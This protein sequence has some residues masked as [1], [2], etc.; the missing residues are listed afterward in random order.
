MCTVPENQLRLSRD[1]GTPLICDNRLAGSLSV[2][3]PS[4]NQYVMNASDSCANTLL[5]NAYYTKMS[6]YVNWIHNI[7]SRYAPQQ[8]LNGQPISLVPTA[9][10]YEGGRTLSLRKIINIINYLF[11]NLT[12]GIMTPVRPPSKGIAT[13]IRS[14]SV[15]EISIAFVTCLFAYFCVLN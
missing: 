11:V 12:A 3:L 15:V 1:R 6:V 13:S 9:P 2:I 7:M 5:T 8:T 4:N 10:P 14:N